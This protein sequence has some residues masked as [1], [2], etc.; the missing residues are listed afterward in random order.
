MQ[1]KH[2]I[3]SCRRFSESGNL[4]EFEKESSMV[5]GLGLVHQEGVLQ[6]KINK[7]YNFY[8]VKCHKSPPKFLKFPHISMHVITDRRNRLHFDQCQPTLG[9]KVYILGRSELWSG[10]CLPHT[11]FWWRVSS[12]G[13]WRQLRAQQRLLLARSFRQLFRFPKSRF[14]GKFWTPLQCIA[15]TG[16]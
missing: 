7:K 11:R 4:E 8:Q 13:A 12:R 10:V 3:S 15:W 14:D 16:Q 5:L 9:W 2:Y 1:N 6:V